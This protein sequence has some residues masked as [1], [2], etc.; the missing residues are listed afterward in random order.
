MY[1]LTSIISD[2]FSHLST[3]HSFF[4]PLKDVSGSRSVEF[5][6]NYEAGASSAFE[7]LGTTWNIRMVGRYARFNLNANE[8]NLTG[9]NFI[10]A[11]GQTYA[12]IANGGSF[13]DPRWVDIQITRL[14]R[15]DYDH[16]K[17]SNFLISDLVG[18]YN[19]GAT[20]DV[21]DAYA[22]GGYAYVFNER[23]NYFLPNQDLLH[24][25]QSP[26]I[27][28]AITGFDNIA[29]IGDATN[30][31]FASG[32]QDNLQLFDDRLVLVGGAR[33]DW[34]W[35]SST[36]YLNTTNLANTAGTD[37]AWTS[38]FG[39]I[40]KPIPAIPGL[41][42]FT[43]RS[44]TFTP[45]VGALNGNPAT[46]EKSLRGLM[47]EGGVK[48][49]LFNGRV[50]GTAS[51]FHGTLSNQIVQPPDVNGSSPAP[52]PA[53]R[54]RHQGIRRATWT[55]SCSRP[56]RR[57]WPTPTLRTEDPNGLYTRDVPEG[58]SYKGLG[59]YTLLDGPL[60]GLAAGFGYIFVSKH[61]GVAGAAFILTIYDYST[62]FLTYR[63]KTWTA[64]LN[65]NNV[66]NQAYAA[67]STSTYEI[68]P[69]PSREVKMSLTYLMK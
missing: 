62:A 37:N 60:K 65:V 22:Y 50:T 58:A 11:A 33:W 10:N 64:Q 31:G 49:D 27:F 6:Y 9:V 69:G 63:A 43:D 17:N 41:A 13:L 42:V 55:S 7:A 48:L 59:K 24:P 45:Q 21:F 35:Q 3:M 44:E 46:P 38:K 15:L 19:W 56:Y 14:E 26:N 4:S 28:N 16:W 18:Q 40:G 53:E 30:V 12:T 23:I 1:Q 52:S 68:D 29:S 61:A 54:K 57:S 8:N 25:V 67:G 47:Y 36:N 34:G 2:N 51:A 39:A 20:R 5:K 32:G 66:F